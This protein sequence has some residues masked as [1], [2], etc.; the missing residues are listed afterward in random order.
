MASRLALLLAPLALVVAP[1]A[2][3]DLPRLIGTVGPGFTI[4]L[5]DG[6]GAHV[7]VVPAGKYELLVHDLSA[8]HNFVL[9]SKSTGARVAATE[10]EFV[11]DQTFTI[12]LVRGFYVYA[13]SP[14][15]QVMFGR[16]TAVAPTVATKTLAATVGTRTVTL[17]ATRVS[18]G[19][20][21][22]RVVDR[23]RSRNFHL[24]GP[25]V[26]RATSKVFSGSVTWTVRLAAGTY[27]FGSDP[28]LT[29]RLVV[30]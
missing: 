3:A 10:V 24:V 25:G 29:G 26:N 1:G 8:E 7:D 18:T 6:R 14:H 5:T 2:H 21:R 9:G 16:V 11:G 12:D 28:R 27:R 4:D 23:S 17:S 22:L 30:G 19:T 15:F 20:Y 13:C